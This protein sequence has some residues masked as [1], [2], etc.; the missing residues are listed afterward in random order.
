M[1]TK[2]ISACLMGNIGAS[3]PR[4]DGIPY[5]LFIF[6]STVN[7]ELRMEILVLTWEDTLDGTPCIY[8]HLGEIY[9]S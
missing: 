5:D 2:H 3:T 6:R 8:S 7:P 4:K 9:N 1:Q